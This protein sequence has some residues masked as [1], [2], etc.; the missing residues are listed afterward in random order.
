[1]YTVPLSS[2]FLF[3]IRCALVVGTEAATEMIFAKDY[4]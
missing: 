3:I 1:M 2:F 4:T